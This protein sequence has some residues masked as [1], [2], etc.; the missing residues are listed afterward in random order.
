MTERCRAGTKSYDN[1]CD[2]CERLSSISTNSSLLDGGQYRNAS[3]DLKL[4]KNMYSVVYS[5]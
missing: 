3:S 5:T 1:L 4:E 2:L